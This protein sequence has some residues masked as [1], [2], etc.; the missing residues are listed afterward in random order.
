MVTGMNG[1]GTRMPRVIFPRVQ[2][3]PNSE[4][5]THMAKAG[6]GLAV[7]FST[8]SQIQPGTQQAENLG[9]SFKIAFMFTTDSKQSERSSSKSINYRVCCTAS[10]THS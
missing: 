4:L 6:V 10:V 5:L 8:A 3:M 7:L 2:S 1:T 9:V